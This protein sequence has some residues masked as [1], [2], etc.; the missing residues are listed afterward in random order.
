MTFYL[1]INCFEINFNNI[2][3]KRKDI[4]NFGFLC[5]LEFNKNLIKRKYNLY[6]G[7]KCQ[8]LGEKTK[9]SLPQAIR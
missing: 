9:C 4:I 5:G 8:E 3:F 1:R 7:A 2:L 6:N